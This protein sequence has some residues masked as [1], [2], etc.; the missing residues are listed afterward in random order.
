M[1]VYTPSE[2]RRPD[3]PLKP[4]ERIALQAE[5][6]KQLR[7]E[8]EQLRAQVA[9]MRE[10]LTIANNYMPDI[11]QFCVC[12]K[13][14]GCGTD[15]GYSGYE[16]CELVNALDKA[17]MLIYDM[18]I[19]KVALP[20]DMIYRWENLVKRAKESVKKAKTTCKTTGMPC[21]RCQ[22]VCEH[23]SFEDCKY[24]IEKE[25]EVEI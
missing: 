9:K 6:I 2:G 14:K 21:C 22:P 1:P 11:G 5:E 13:C 15:I 18:S 17:I 3:C 25:S 10:A 8:N 24:G 4:E 20:G 19:R 12:G 7:Q 16:Y 23:R